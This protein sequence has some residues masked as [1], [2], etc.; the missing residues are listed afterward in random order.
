M[1]LVGRRI[2]FY[3]PSLE[4]GGAERQALHLARWLKEREGAEVKVWGHVLPG[5]AARWCEQAGLPWAVH[6]CKVGR[7]LK[8]SWRELLR[9]AFRLRLAR[10]EVL[11][12]YCALPNVVCGRL[13]RL[14]G[15]ELC[16]WNQRDILMSPVNERLER[17]AV[18][19]VPRFVANSENAADV[20]ARHY[21]IARASIAVVPNGIS[22]DAPVLDR[23]QWRQKLGVAA[24]DFVAVMIGNLSRHKD[25]ATLLKAWQTVLRGM[26][27]G[28]GGSLVLAG[29]RGES[30]ESLEKLS[31]ELGIR[32]K[33]LFPGQI[34]D[35]A[36][37]LAACDMG[38]LSS[39]A[40]GCPNGLLECMAA[41][42]AVVG[43]DIAG[44]RE[45]LGPGGAKWLAPE[46][47][48][49]GLARRMLSL[50]NDPSLRL[51]EGGNN[52]RRVESC[53][54]VER[55]CRMMVEIIEA[56]LRKRD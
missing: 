26:P 22:L 30:S 23:G 29:Y 47:D 24:D 17:E 36:G 32:D 16:I 39:H 55:S 33:V 12:P 19:R 20:L 11:L 3:L 2:Q 13:W 53:F 56:G 40:E 35:V 42:L 44:I 48:Y 51:T 1:A 46:R 14:A 15:A 37:L 25:H 21:G 34:E 7:D 50:A 43:T 6:P 38:V 45:V 5:L 8:Q 49:E 10:P 31:R 9:I 27:R 28:L 18:S 54:S 41:G 4:G 52:R